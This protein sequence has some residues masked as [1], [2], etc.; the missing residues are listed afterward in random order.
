MTTT[1]HHPCPS[2]PA[3]LAARARSILACPASLHVAVGHANDCHHEELRRAVSLGT[4]TRP[5]D[6]LAVQ[7]ARLTADGVQVQWVDRDGA[8][9]QEVRFPRPARD[10]AEL[11]DLLRRTLHAGIC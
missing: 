5:G 1:Q 10:L 7:L 9:L 6:L 3:L 2:D 11:R 8:H 4:G